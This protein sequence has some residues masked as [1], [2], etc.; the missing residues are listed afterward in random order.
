MLKK[1][2]ELIRQAA[3]KAYPKEMCGV[4]VKRG[5]SV[6]FLEVPNIHTDPTRAFA[7]CQKTLGELLDGREYLAVVHSHP[8]GKA[9]PSEGDR[10]GIEVTDVP[11]YI[12]SVFRNLLGNGQPI[13]G[14]IL[15]YDP[16]GYEAPLLNRE[17]FHGVQDCYTLIQD[18][19]KRACNLELPNFEREDDW[20]TKPG[21][22]LYLK[23]FEEA[24]FVVVTDEVRVGDIF[25][26]N[27]QSKAG[28][29]HAAI[30]IGG[31]QI[32]H[33]LYDK[34]S[35]VAIYGGYWQRNTELRIRH[36]AFIEDPDR[37]PDNI[38]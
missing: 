18:Y 27:L 24:G 35:S 32:I 14:D 21:E 8:D 28:P 10:V 36:R 30:Y 31:D 20:W 9:E 34:L 12:V 25:L 38:L 23:G 13:V 19:F 17:F 1:N 4:L 5:R 37:V 16:C 3:V 2:E 6:E 29:N 22:S 7:M 11:W 15:R 33:H 26:I